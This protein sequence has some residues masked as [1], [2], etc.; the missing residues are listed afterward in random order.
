MKAKQNKYIDLNQFPHNQQGKI[1]WND[2]IGLVVEFYYNDKSHKIK[3]LE[4]IN[5]DYFKIMLDD[6]IIEKSH[7]SKITGLMFDNLLYKP[8]YLYNVGE[9]IN[10]KLE[11]LEQRQIQRKTT[12]GKGSVNLKAYLCQCLMDGYKFV[13]TE[14]DLKNGHGCPVCA[15]HTIIKG[16]NDIGTTDSELVYLFVDENDAY[17]HCRS[18]NEKVYVRC[19]YC[20]TIKKMSINELTMRGYVTCDICSD[21]ISYPN[22]FSHEL[23]KQLSKQYLEY[24]SEYSP[25]WVGKLR[26]DNYIKLPDGREVIV[27]MDGGFH[28][29]DRHENI[30]KNDLYKDKLA[31]EHGISM[32]RI[33][34]NYFRVGQRYSIIKTNLIASLKDLFDLSNVDWDKCNEMATSSKLI[35]VLNYYHDNPKLGLREIAKDCNISMAT[36]YEYLYIG[37]EMGLCTYIRADSNRIKNSK[38]IAMYDLNMN[39]IGIYKSGKQI[40]ELFP[41]LKFSHRQIRKCATSNKPYKNYIFRFATYEEYQQFG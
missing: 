23:F 26:Y 1:V 29:N 37:E 35:E 4:R 9:I 27:E 30:I 31:K 24:V 36:L 19:P 20:G 41:E 39:L 16:I 13:T 28:Y 21:G 8:N 6:I 11:V 12:Q 38:P 18:S 7:T 3:F 17:C 34:C 14:Y 33:N 2:C 10:G 40:T 32:I 15:N 5:K 22:K 25:S